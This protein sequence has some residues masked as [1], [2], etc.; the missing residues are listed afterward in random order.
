MNTG[1]TY[2]G[3]TPQGLHTRLTTGFTSTYKVDHRV[4]ILDL[5]TRLTHWADYG[6]AYT[7]GLYRAYTLGWLWQ[8][9]RMRF[10]ERAYTLGWLWRSY[11]L[12][13]LHISGYCCT[14]GFTG[15]VRCGVYIDL[16]GW[17]GLQF[18]WVYTLGWL[19]K[20]FLQES[21]IYYLKWSNK[22]LREHQII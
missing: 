4:Y 14:I 20:S 9:L 5:S 16:G 1:S 18:L 21:T 7:W 17:L 22:I 6:E 15:G 19:S 10:M 11:V 3:F 8:G 2:M 13:G 12:Q